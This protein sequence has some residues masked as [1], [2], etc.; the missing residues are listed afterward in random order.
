MWM[1]TEGTENTDSENTQEWG[2]NPGAKTEE[3]H[4]DM[5]ETGG[6]NRGMPTHR[7]GK[8]VINFEQKKQP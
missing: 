5:K 3:K 6:W 2:R 8:R 4:M 1:G 7:N